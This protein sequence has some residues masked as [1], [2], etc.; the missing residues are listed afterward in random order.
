M[1]TIER[2]GVAPIVQKMMKNLLRW[3]GQVD[4]SFVDSIYSNESRSD[5]E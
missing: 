4:R 5:G 2:V 3:F 1:T